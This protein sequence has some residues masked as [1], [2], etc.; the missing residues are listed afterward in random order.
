M[1]LDPIK[2]LIR[3]G[4]AAEDNDERNI[5]ASCYKELANFCFPKLR[6]VD[7]TASTQSNTALTWATGVPEVIEHEPD[8]EPTTPQPKPALSSADVQ[9]LL[10]GQ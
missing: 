3:L 8:T 4:R 6:S 5:A 7:L 10:D 2:A 1:G 9:R